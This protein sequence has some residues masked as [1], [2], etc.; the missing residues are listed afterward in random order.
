MI[1]IVCSA[2]ITKDNKVLLVQENKMDK[3]G[4]PGGKLENGESLKEC[5][6][7]ELKE[8][9]GADITIG[10]LVMVSEKP[11]T[12]EGNTVLRYIFSAEITSM[13]EER[14]MTYDYYDQAQV[15]AIV[16]D[17]RLR[18]KDVESLLHAYFTAELTPL[19]EPTV[20]I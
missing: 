7:R 2:L 11:F 1:R 8:E 14:E 3:L 9:L 13:T 19:P 5:V 4:I 17:D 16:A 15:E 10:P 6:K 18:G 20:F 12:R